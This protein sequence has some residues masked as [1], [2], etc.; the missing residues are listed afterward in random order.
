VKEGRQAGE[1][2]SRG[3]GDYAEARRLYQESLDIKLQLGDR[4]GVASSLHQ[5]G[6]LAHDQG[7]YPE[8]R[9]L[10]QESLDIELRLGDRASVARTLHQLGRLAEVDGDLEEAEQLFAE[11]LA[12][13]EAL[14][15]PDAEVARRSL[16][17]VRG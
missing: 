3:A 1:Q 7:N 6:M 9:R 15:S 4:A 16:G 12:T 5:L 8:A 17:R 2:G 11:S 13:L 14:G 10:Y